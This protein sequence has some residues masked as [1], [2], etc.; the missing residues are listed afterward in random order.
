MMKKRD[1]CS[2]CPV[3]CKNVIEYNNESISI[4]SRYGGPEYE[5]LGALALSAPSQTLSL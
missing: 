3:Y 5:T 4:D 1:N 2:N